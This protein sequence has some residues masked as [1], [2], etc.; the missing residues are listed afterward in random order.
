M[1]WQTTHQLGWIE[2][3]IQREL[4]RR[5]TQREAGY[6]LLAQKTGPQ[7]AKSAEQRVG[8]RR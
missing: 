3:V 4:V 5:A 1:P 7:F 2:V 8:M 6:N